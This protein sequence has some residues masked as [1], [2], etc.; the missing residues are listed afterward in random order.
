MH[1]ILPSL[2]LLPKPPGIKIPDALVNFFLISEDLSLSDSILI[3]FI[4][5]LFFIPPWTKASSKDLYASFKSTYLPTIAIFI[6]FKFLSVTI[7]VTFFHGERLIF[8]FWFYFKV[9]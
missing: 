3:N 8:F 4:F 5:T 2:P 6:T 7:L 1:E 9:F